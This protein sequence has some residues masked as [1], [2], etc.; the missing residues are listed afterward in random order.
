MGSIAEWL[1]GF[2]AKIKT[3]FRRNKSEPGPAP[4]TVVISEMHPSA[5]SS[6]GIKGITKPKATE[7]VKPTATEKK[8]EGVDE[9]SP[10]MTRTR[11]AGEETHLKNPKTEPEPS[12]REPGVIETPEIPSSAPSFNQPKYTFQGTNEGIRRLEEGHV[13]MS[14][15]HIPFPENLRPVED[16]DPHLPNTPEYFAQVQKHLD[17]ESGFSMNGIHFM[18]YRDRHPD[19]Q[20]KL[21]RRI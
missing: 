17:S 6:D 11:T 13:T 15:N 8:A 9:G 5:K 20:P 14:N 1:K 4:S 21:F 3:L 2:M 18:G 10:L 16:S 7:I 12:P 19:V